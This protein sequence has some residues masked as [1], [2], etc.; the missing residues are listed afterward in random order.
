MTDEQ[1]HITDER[2]EAAM[3]GDVTLTPEEAVAAYRRGHMTVSR[4]AELAGLRRE[5][6]ETVL[7]DM[8]VQPSHGPRDPAGL[9]EGVA[10]DE[11]YTEYAQTRK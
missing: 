2:F 1:P 6:M 5:E 4:A 8:N 11:H 7:V 9:S 3:R 10:L